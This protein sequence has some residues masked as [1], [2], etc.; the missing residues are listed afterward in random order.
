ME[1]EISVA[2]CFIGLV[3]AIAC[4]LMLAAALV[5][6]ISLMY[7]VSYSPVH[8]WKLP[9]ALPLAVGGWWLLRWINKRVDT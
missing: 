1:G 7:A 9:L 6:M 5:V 2:K 3:A 4:L 8:L